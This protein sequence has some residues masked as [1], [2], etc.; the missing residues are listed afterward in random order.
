[1]IPLT[2]KPHQLLLKPSKKQQKHSKPSITNESIHHR[3]AKQVNQTLKTLPPDLH[4]QTIP[5]S[6]QIESNPAHAH[7]CA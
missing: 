7:S 6:S 1:M 3:P 5:R 4:N 2:L